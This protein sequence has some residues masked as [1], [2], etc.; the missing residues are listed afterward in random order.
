MPQR[1]SYTNATSIAIDC[2]YL[3]CQK[4]FAVHILRHIRLFE[5]DWMEI[6]TKLSFC[7]I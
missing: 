3:Q 4:L 7:S 6:I 1:A 5:M 2:N